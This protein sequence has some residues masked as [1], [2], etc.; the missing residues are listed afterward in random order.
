M[1]DQ[2]MTVSPITFLT[3]LLYHPFNVP[4]AYIQLYHRPVE[5]LN[6]WDNETTQRNFI[7]IYAPDVHE[8]IRIFKN[9][10][11]FFPMSNDILPIAHNH[12]I[13]E[14]PFSDDFIQDKIKLYNAIK[15][16]HLYVAIDMLQD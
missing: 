15:K 9:H 7:G 2:L 8:A 6:R 4:A 12:V 3:G 16:G 10:K 11:L 5:A 1:T 13:L 14:G